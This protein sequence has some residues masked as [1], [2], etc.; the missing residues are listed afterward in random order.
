MWDTDDMERCERRTRRCAECGKAVPKDRRQP[1][2]SD[3][4][5][6]AADAERLDSGE[7]L[8]VGGVLR[9]IAAACSD[10]G[11][12][13]DLRPLRLL[14]DPSA[15]WLCVDTGACVRRTIQA[16]YWLTRQARRAAA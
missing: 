12:P 8:P 14:T 1:E 3:C 15:K 7:W 10:C 6:L 13:R 9:W 2:C 16:A 11:N 5:D 4:L